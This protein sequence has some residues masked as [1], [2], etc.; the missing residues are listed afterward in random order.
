MEYGVLG[1]VPGA[2]WTAMPRR[3]LSGAIAGGVWF[4]P[5]ACMWR[6]A[7][8]DVAESPPGNGR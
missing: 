8:V 6:F 2:S 7:A 3:G 5:E 1:T 4:V